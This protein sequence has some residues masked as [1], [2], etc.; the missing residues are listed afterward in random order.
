[1]SGAEVAQGSATK[2][3]GGTGPEAQQ[4]LT[5]RIMSFLV[6]GMQL[7]EVDPSLPT[8]VL[9]PFLELCLAAQA[10]VGY[11]EHPFPLPVKHQSTHGTP[12]IP[13]EVGCNAWT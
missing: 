5:D 12:G 11:P 4:C 8:Q 6:H 13:W 1:M 9:P 7:A 10:F 2:P 3:R